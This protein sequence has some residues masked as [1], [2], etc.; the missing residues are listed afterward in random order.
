MKKILLTAALSLCLAGPVFAAATPKG[1]SVITADRITLGDVFD[2]VTKNA[3][4]YLAPAPEVGKTMT[5]GVYDLTRISRAFHLGWSPKSSAERVVIRR[6]SNRIDRYDIQA[7]LE[8]RLKEETGGQKF[9]M[10]LLDR[11]VSFRVADLS[12]RTVTVNHLSYDAVK[13]EFSAVVSAAAEPGIKKEVKGRIHPISQIPVLCAPLRPGDVISAD[14]IDYI[15]MHA[16]DITPA[17]LTSAANLIGHS[18][19]RGVP[20]MK[21]LIASD[22]QMPVL[23]KKGD[24]V[25]MTLKNS[26]MSLTTQGRALDNGAAGEAVRIMNSTSKQVIDGI[27]TGTMAVSVQSPQSLL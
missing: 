18:P 10:E 13:G 25:T 7:A 22:I 11:S 6:A 21:P 26:T 9:D 1:E 8:K 5:L 16:A 14:D 17:M 20:A 2:G 3:D 4:H 15:D 19:R 27:V 24:L 12:D 23:V